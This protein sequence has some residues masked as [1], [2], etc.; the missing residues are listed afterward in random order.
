MTGDGVN[1]A[2]AVKNADIGICMGK[3]GTD[4]T[5]DASEM[6][7]LDEK[8]SSIAAAIE[9][10]RAIYANIR[11]F[12]RYLLACNT[13]E[14]LTM[15]VA[16]FFCLPLPILPVQ[17]LWVNL[18]TDGLPALA[19]GV[20][21]NEKSLMSEKPRRKNESIFSGGLGRKIIVK[22]LQIGIG[23]VLLFMLILY[24]TH[25]LELARTMA[26]TNLVFSQMFHTVE[27]RSEKA[28]CFEAGIFKN[29]LLLGAVGISAAMHIGVIYIPWLQ[30]IFSTMPLSFNEWLV[31][32]A[33]SGWNF[34]LAAARFAFCKKSH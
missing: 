17:I 16:S 21:A 31:I 27:C 23:T 34:I 28:S 20:D 6:L 1:D 19:L 9:E 29:R 11:K 24:T 18:V 2:P 30:N 14:V 33:F 7:L 15:L 22:G 8:F 13:G 32:L 12:I 5:R 25:D 4:I 10:G 3:T 26:F